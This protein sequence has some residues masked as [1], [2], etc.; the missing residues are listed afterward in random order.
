MDWLQLF[1]SN[2]LGLALDAAPWLLLGL[3]LAGLIKAWIPEQLLGRWLGGKGLPAVMRAS[4]VGAPL[5]LCSCG[6]IP[7]AL[8]LHRGGASRGASTAFMVGTPG[9]GVDSVALTYVLLGPV[10]A[11]IR[12]LAA[13]FSAVVTGM[14]VGQTDK[15]SAAEPPQENKLTTAASPAAN[16]CSGS[17]SCRLPDAPA[18]HS[19][20]GGLAAFPAAP[21]RRAALAAGLRY[22]F[23]EVLDDISWWLLLGLLLAGLLLTMIPPGVL[24]QYAT[25]LPAMLLMAVIGIPMY[26]CAQAATPVAAALVISGVS[27]GTALVFLLAGPITSIATLT[28]FR[29]EFGTGAMALYVMGVAGSAVLCGLLTDTLIAFLVWDLPTQIDT[30]RE[31]LP[32]GVKYPALLLL[33]VMAVRPVR[34]RFF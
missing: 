16:S 30:S 2:T 12:P 18:V 32:A 13:I 26:L 29:N 19:A 24:A 17:C 4:L 14:L 3:A 21:S 31:L 6:A 9:V 27:P 5:P 1:F 28:V 15:A 20:E 25:G 7:L 23:T 34:R 11:V 22:S 10:L 8:A 33:L